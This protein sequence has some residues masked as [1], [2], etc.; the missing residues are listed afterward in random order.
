MKGI[1]DHCILFIICAALSNFLCGPLTA[2]PVTLTVL[3]MASVMIYAANRKV[4][5][6]M[7]CLYVMMCLICPAF[8]IFMPIMLYYSVWYKCYVSYMVVVVGLLHVQNFEAWVWFAIITAIVLSG[9]LAYDSKRLYELEKRFIVLR[10]T[11]KERDML[12]QEK[13]HKLMEK[14]DYEIYLATLKERN[15]IAREIHDNV[16][17]MLTRSILQVGALRAVY[18]DE[19]LTG[20]LESVNETLNQAMTSIRKSIHNLHDDAID[21]RSAIEEATKE[22]REHY[23]LTFDYDMSSDVVRNVKYCF[24]AIVK[25]AMSNIVK[26]SN[27]DSVTIIMREHPG[28]YQMSI[29]DNGTV[30]TDNKPGIGLINM[31]ERVNALG[32]RIYI[33]NENGFCIFITV[34]KSFDGGRN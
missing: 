32:G 25:E 22:V 20:Q 27:G 19:P 11:S 24:I 23:K 26:Y 6:A 28:F 29:E 9:I 31:K 13:N 7:L 2:V 34:K 16:G 8:T 5:I 10:D 4:W 18:T 12:L 14:Q 17:H 1:R 15:R 21:L 3:T 30:K 33:Q